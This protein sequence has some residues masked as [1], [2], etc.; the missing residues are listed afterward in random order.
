M[1]ITFLNSFAVSGG[2]ASATNRLY[3]ALK[4]KGV[5]VNGIG[6]YRENSNF[7]YYFYKH[8]L[9]LLALE[10]LC[11]LP[12]EK[13]KN[14]RF[15]FSTALF[16]KNPINNQL[17]Q[18]ADIIHLHWINQG[19]LSLK[20]LEALAGLGKPIVW[21]M[22]DMW[23]I[24]GGCHHSRSCDHYKNE[25]GD[26]F[27]LR[28]PR[29]DDLSHKIWEK[30]KRIYSK[31]NFH[32]IGVSDWITS[33]ARNSSLG[34]ETTIHTLPNPLDTTLFQPKEKASIKELKGISPEITTISFSAFNLENKQKG[35]YIFKEALSIL[36]NQ[37]P[38]L[39]NTCLLL[40]SG[41][42]SNEIALETL[43][44]PYQYHGLIT[45][46]DEMAQFYQSS[47]IY[48]TSSLEESLG[49]TAM[50]ALACETP[51]IS[52]SSGGIIE[53]VKD[54]ETGLIA[55]FGNANSLA[56]KTLQLIEDQNLRKK[57]GKTG[58]KM[59]IGK[60][61]PDVVAEQHIKLYNDIV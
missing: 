17:I 30:K 61:S 13:N 20:S 14:V 32:L 59:I 36:I 26:C 47:D 33:F 43:P 46:E 40:L 23:P 3:K 55:E 10:K 39:A 5:N 52:F 42:I 50:E 27:Y 53:L 54:N 28:K 18:E 12:Y 7:D 22:H 38:E 31:G 8:G 24:T 4:S 9:A 60:Y 15:Q 35:F 56:E 16:G 29:K 11:F 44:I 48:V 41:K 1:N 6:L 37:K 25:C 19:L 45:N 49:Y 21:T 51:V 2:A 57:L 34:E 58:A